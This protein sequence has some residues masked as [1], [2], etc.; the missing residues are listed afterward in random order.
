MTTMNILTFENYI[1]TQNIS[2]INVIWKYSVNQKYSVIQ[3]Y[4][5]AFRDNK[6]SDFDSQ[7]CSDI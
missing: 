4:L 5:T 2:T 3:K 6:N 7:K 1:L